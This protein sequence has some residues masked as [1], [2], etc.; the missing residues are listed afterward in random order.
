MYPMHS[1]GTFRFHRGHQNVFVKLFVVSVF[2]RVN[3]SGLHHIIS[4]RKADR[5]QTGST[6]VG[7]QSPARK[8]NQQVGSPWQPFFMTHL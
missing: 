1:L 6:T 5:K 2:F 8:K 3:R 7:L 4:A